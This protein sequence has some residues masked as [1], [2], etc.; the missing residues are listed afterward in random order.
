MS[1]LPE[2]TAQID[3]LAAFPAML[4]RAL[5]GVSDRALRHRPAPGEWSVVEVIGHIIDVDILMAARIERI[6]TEE[7][8]PIQMQDLVAAVRDAGYQEQASDVIFAQ[9]RAHREA[10]VTLLRGLPTGAAERTG[11]H[12][13]RGAQRIADLVG[14][15]ARH[16][17][18]HMEQIRNTLA[19][20][21]QPLGHTSRRAILAYQ[22]R[23]YD[24][25]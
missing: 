21:A 10:L 14:M 4:S 19:S 3:A 9:F 1:D 23:T 20:A 25:L 5:D 13:A 24:H 2:F 17:P 16:G 12:P 8:P 18:N 15:V 6:A 22:R 7:S 11:I